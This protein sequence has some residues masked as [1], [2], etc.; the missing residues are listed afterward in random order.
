[1]D[2]KYFARELKRLLDY[3]EPDEAHHYEECEIG[4]RKNHIYSTIK[5]LRNGCH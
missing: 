4:D 1:M 5:Y 2:K 3:C